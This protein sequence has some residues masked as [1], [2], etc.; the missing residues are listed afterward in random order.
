MDN[1]SK[2]LM[3]LFMA[4][5]SGIFLLIILMKMDVVEKKLTPRSKS[6]GPSWIGKVICTVRQSRMC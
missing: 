4:I 2:A 3:I 6:S 5:G 1:T